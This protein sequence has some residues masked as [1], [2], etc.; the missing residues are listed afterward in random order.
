MVRTREGEKLPQFDSG[1]ERLLIIQLSPA[2]A[3]DIEAA[4]ARC[5][6]TV[7]RCDSLDDA[8]R[9]VA[10]EPVYTV[11]VVVLDGAAHRMP[12]NGDALIEGFQAIQRKSP[13]TQLIVVAA[14][15]LEMSFCC[16][17]VNCGV[18]GFLELQ[19]GRLDTAAVETQLQL[20]DARYQ[21]LRAEAKRIHSGEIFDSTGIVGCSRAMAK[22]LSQGARAAE[23]SDVPVLIYGE[24]GTGKQL[25]AEMIHRLDPKRASKPFLSVNCAAITGTLAESAMFGHVKGAYTGA[26]ESRAGYFRAADG[27]TV[28]L[29]EIGDLA[30][31][32]QPKLLRFL[33]EGVV[34]PV[35]SDTEHPTDVRIIAAANR[36][37][38]ALVEEG[39][40]R[41]DLYQRLNVIS[42]EIPPLR[43]RREDITLLIDFFVKKY[44]RY[45]DKPIKRIEQRVYDLFTRAALQGNVRELENTIRRM[46]AMKTIGDEITLNDVPSSI[47]AGYVKPVRREETLLPKEIVESVA[48]LIMSGALTLPEFVDECERL[49]LGHAIEQNRDGNADLSQQLGLSTRTLYNKRR[50]HAL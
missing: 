13:D 48:G 33:Q 18:S 3:D 46:L 7:D 27:G 34:M 28:F 20:A 8:L 5:A 14:S 47:L 1:V 22:V 6:Q 44:S 49:I 11:V 24:S 43:E 50:K 42:F 19:N 9:R 36:R 15:A 23:V 17:A 21:R 10:D 38:P 30:P 32:L 31:E 12:E 45:Y 26:T 40:F 41:L 16:E 29:D 35:G 4:F 39:L 2:G 25:L 37:I